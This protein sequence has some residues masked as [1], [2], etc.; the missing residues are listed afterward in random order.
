M[1]WYQASG[2]A[3]LLLPH[4]PLAI[5]TP[6]DISGSSALWTPDQ[7]SSHP[8]LSGAS[9]DSPAP[10]SKGPPPAESQISLHLFRPPFSHKHKHRRT[11]CRSAMF[12]PAAGLYS[13]SRVDPNY[14]LLRLKKAGF[15]S[16]VQLRR[17]DRL[18]SSN[19]SLT[20]CPNEFAL[21]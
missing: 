15:T 9:P 13:C 12:E 11:L 18:K 17:C 7:L 20:I 19:P 6:T 3:A 4:D 2:S 21:A 16:S 10:P 1:H 5:S 8:Q 14:R